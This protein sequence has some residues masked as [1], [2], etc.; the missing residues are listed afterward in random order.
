MYSPIRDEVGLKV[1][2]PWEQNTAN[3]FGLS[4]VSCLFLLFIFTSFVTIDSI[5]KPESS[6]KIYTPITL[7][8][9]NFGAGDGTGRSKGNLT[10]EGMA[11]KGAQ[12][13][14]NLHDASIAANTQAVAN[15]SNIDPELA[16]NIIAVKDLPAESSKKGAANGNGV[17]NIGTPNGS[18]FGDGLGGRGSGRG[19]GLGLGDIEWGGGGNRTVLNKQLPEFPRGSKPGQVK[20][21]FTVAADGTVLTARPTVKGGDPNLE[22]AAIQAIKMW[23][24]N[25]LKEKKDMQGIITFTFNLR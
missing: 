16:N 13:P 18:V 9:I 4:L 3:G 19:A 25:P 23:R 6:D 7:E 5:T 8:T 24:F 22:R 10:E 12:A 21:S 11:H 20:I 1:N 17:A 14:T 2:I 15:P